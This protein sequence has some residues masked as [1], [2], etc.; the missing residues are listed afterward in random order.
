MNGSARSSRQVHAA[1]LYLALQAATGA[2]WWVGVYRSDHLRDLTLGTWNPD[3]LVV[4]DVALFCGASL[5]AAI[6]ARWALAILVAAWSVILTAA[7]FLSAFET[8]DAGWGVA[9]MTVASVCT[10][11]AAAVLKNGSLPTTWFFRGPFQFRPATE[12]PVQTHVV[13]SITQLIVFWTVLL[14][15]LPIIAARLEHHLRIDAQWLDPDALATVGGALFATSSCLGLWSC[16][17]MAS[18]GHGTPLPSA[19]ARDL[20]NRGPYRFVRNPMAVAGVGQTVGVGLVLGSW[21]VIVAAFV[22]ATMW[23]TIIRPVEEADLAERLG[24]DYELY[25]RSVRC[26]IPRG[27]SID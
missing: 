25:E 9:V 15:L 21:V 18:H 13:H 17:V 19:T 6:T 16:I 14:G 22:G 1:R 27:S 23:D 8:R 4:P 26:W 24:N 5:G 7:L 11:V 12:H 20:V 3:L 2:G 10:L